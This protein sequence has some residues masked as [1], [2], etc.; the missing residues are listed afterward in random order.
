M[1]HRCTQRWETLEPI[2]DKPRV[3]YCGHCGSVVHLVERENEFTEL[4][5]QGKCTAMAA[6]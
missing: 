3:R 2:A 4:A 1:S 6:G 5:R